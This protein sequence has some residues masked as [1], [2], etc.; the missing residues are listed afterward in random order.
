ME[1]L[2][3]MD[4]FLYRYGL[5]RHDNGDI[6]GFLGG[7]D[8]DTTSSSS[9]LSA[10][11]HA[12]DQKL[13]FIRNDYLQDSLHLVLL[14]KGT[15]NF[16]YDIAPD[17]KGHRKAP[18]PIVGELKDW[19]L[20][21]YKDWL[22]PVPEG[23]SGESDDILA[24]IQRKNPSTTVIVGIDKDFHTVPGWKYHPFTGDLR[25]VNKFSAELMFHYQHLMGDSADGIPGCLGVG[26][27]IAKKIILNAV[28][29]GGLRCLPKVVRMAYEV[30]G[31][32]YVKCGKL[33]YLGDPRVSQWKPL[34]R[35]P[36]S[37]S[38]VLQCAEVQ[39]TKGRV[40]KC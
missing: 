33:L 39:Q 30:Q 15:P 19:V 9:R 21:T 27:K 3:D 37:Y 28:A 16:R 10:A 35:L 32:D 11:Q 17:Y 29:E 4:C 26:D 5:M 25:F 2:V 40:S 22:V 18:D 8:E 38:V 6:S 13:E 36:K 23:F 34:K 1:I 12:I 14:P 31:G 7:Y 24:D 20:E